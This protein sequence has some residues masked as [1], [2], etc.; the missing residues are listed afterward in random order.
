MKNQEKPFKNSKFLISET[1][2]ARFN[3]SAE[4]DEI[5]NLEK[6]SWKE[7]KVV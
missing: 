2:F 6:Y 4:K 5:F 1:L 3:L 7:Q